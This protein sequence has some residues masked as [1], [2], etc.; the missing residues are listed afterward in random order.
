MSRIIPPSSFFFVFILSVCT[1]SSL[2]AGRQVRRR[3]KIIAIRLIL[4]I[5]EGNLRRLLNMLKKLRKKKTAKKIWIVLAILILPAFVLWGS[6]SVTRSKQESSSIGRI[7]GRNISPLEF[8]DAFTAVKNQALI[9]FGDNFS[10][11]Q[12]NLD[13]ETRTW[14]RMVL[15]YEAKRRGMRSSDKEVEELI[16][17]YPFFQKNGQ[18][19]NG[20]YSEMLQYVF[21]TQPRIFEEETRQNILLGKLYKQVTNGIAVNDEEIKE[22][23]RKFNEEISVNYIQADPA[24][25]AKALSPSEQELKDYFAKNSL[26]FKQPLSFNLDSIVSDSEDKIKQAYARLNK[27]ESLEK[28]AK[29]MGIEVKETG[30]F[31]QTDAIPGIGWSAE[32]MNLVIKLKA[33]RYSVP[34]KVDKNYYILRLKDKKESYIPEFEKIKDKVREKFIKDRSRELAEAKIEDCYTKLSDAKGQD[35]SKAA[36]EFG[37]KSDSTGMFKYGSYIEGIGA[38][39]E[40]WLKANELKETEFSRVLNIPSGFYI[41]KVKSRVAVDEKKFDNEK[42]EFGKLVL[43]QKQREF[44]AKFTQ[45]LIKK[46]Q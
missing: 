41:I 42:A 6:G 31:G 25:F 28:I 15:L 30:F 12:K 40:L 10:K 17:S 46:A 33:G 8:Q 39:D 21:R 13:L 23:Y 32:I 20:V 2:P 4:T 29:D 45:G 11:I 3:D 35:F 7:F 44:F 14:E 24:D 36:S 34:I 27:K 18:F 26:A 9:Q 43:E 38:S 1:W 5:I 16:A 19:D 37:L 22:E